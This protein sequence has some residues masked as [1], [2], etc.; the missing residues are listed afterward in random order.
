MAKAEESMN[1]FDIIDAHVHTDYSQ[2]DCKQPMEGYLTLVREGKAKGFGFTDHMHPFMEAM[3]ERYE[4]IQ[5]YPF[6]GEAY[7]RQISAA[8]AEGLPVYAGIEVSY[9]AAWDDVCRKRALAYPF[10][11]RVASAH[12]LDGLWVTRTYWQNV[13]PGRMMRE[14]VDRYYDAVLA[15]LELDW[16]DVI[17]HIGVYRRFLPDS[18][19]LMA[20][21]GAWVDKREEEVAKACAK[22][23]KIVEVNTSG[24]TAP[25]A[26]TMPTAQ[27]LRHY[28]TH[29]GTRLCLA[30]DAHAVA[31]ANDHFAH[32]AALLK[33][34]GFDR[35][36][37]PWAKE[38]PVWL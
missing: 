19:P 36:T 6:R 17:A 30:S 34:L 9:E 1:D 25:G 32:T 3:A 38:S 18:H 15:S 24:V 26:C 23:G 16:A 14:I 28:K 22:S 12:S 11:Y 20:Y 31:R 8:K 29:G 33:D 13:Q 21:I 4:G 10:D 37:L 7:I 27:F 35:L 5:A 2:N